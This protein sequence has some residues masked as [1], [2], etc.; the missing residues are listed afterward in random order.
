MSKILSR[1]AAF[2]H[3]YF[4]EKHAKPST[5]FYRRFLT[6]LKKVVHNAKK[7]EEHGYGSRFNATPFTKTNQSKVKKYF[8]RFFMEN[9]EKILTAEG[10]DLSLMCDHFG[11]NENLPTQEKQEAVYEKFADIAQSSK[12]WT[13]AEVAR[14]K[15][16]FLKQL[17]TSHFP[18]IVCHTLGIKESIYKGWLRS[19]LEFSEAVR[20]TQQRFGERI[21]LNLMQKAEEGDLGAQMYALK[22]FEGVVKYTD[23]AAMGQEVSAD[24]DISRLTPQEQEELLRLMDKAR[25][26]ADS[27]DTRFIEDDAEFLDASGNVIAK[28]DVAG[29][30]TKGEEARVFEE[31]AD[32]KDGVI[33]VE[34]VSSAEVIYEEGD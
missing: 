24:M 19:D 26:G 10:S 3:F 4:M 14:Q 20:Q 17:E 21:A 8:T 23:P 1:H 11:I 27:G 31:E 18:N 25:T 12:E 7:Y 16:N 13:K 6:S 15:R 30:I 22:Q 34:P 2:H 33:D 32:E 29:L 28:E 9:E 5:S